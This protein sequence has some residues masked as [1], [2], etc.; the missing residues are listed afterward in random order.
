[1][2]CV[3]FALELSFVAPQ[4]GP[5][6]TELSL[7]QTLTTLTSPGPTFAPG[8]GV[9]SIASR[10]NGWPVVVTCTSRVWAV[11]G[12]SNEQHNIQLFSRKPKVGSGLVMG[13]PSTRHV[14]E[15]LSTPVASLLSSM[16]PRTTTAVPRLVHVRSCRKVSQLALT[17][18]GVGERRPGHDARVRGLVIRRPK[19]SLTVRARV[20][21]PIGTIGYGGVCIVYNHLPRHGGR[22]KR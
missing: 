6:T 12:S 20:G 13:V 2:V 9:T 7:F 10:R 21:K 15:G 14:H 11:G 8:N 19:V 3:I 18:K 17:I 16:V 22:R 4:P 1:M 5:N